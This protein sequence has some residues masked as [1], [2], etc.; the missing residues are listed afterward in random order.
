MP[1]WL[2]VVLIVLVVF[3]VGIGAA[4]WGIYTWWQHEGA[5]LVATIDEGK[6]FARGKDRNACVDE[7]VT[8]IKRDGGFTGAVKVKLFLTECLSA[9]RATPGFC[10]NVPAQSE[11]LKSVT[12][13][14]EMNK[15]YGLSGS[16]EGSLLSEIQH[17]CDEDARL[18]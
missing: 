5:G 10:D 1:T 9:A 15:K 14:Q 6:A 12:W 8:R 11:V 4:G 18:R 7:A 13:L 16:L 2:K 17:I 3:V